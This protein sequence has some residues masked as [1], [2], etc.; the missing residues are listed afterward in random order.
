VA[1]AVLGVQV[2]QTFD[3]WDALRLQ[4]FTRTITE[5][6]TMYPFGTGAGTA[7]AV[8]MA[9]ASFAGQNGSTVDTVVGDS[10]VLTVLR[11]TGW[12]GAVCYLGACLSVIAM[13]WR[14]RTSLLGL[15][16]LGF[17]AGSF[18]NLMN[19]TDVYPTRLYL[20][21]LAAMAGAHATKEE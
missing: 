20:W 1:A 13:T 14:A 17:W 5:S 19:A 4:Q 7:G 16:A 10:V 11:D 21:L 2:V 8:S 12:L 15:V 18:V 9:A 6:V 3:E